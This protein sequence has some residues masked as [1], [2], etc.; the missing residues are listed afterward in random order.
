MRLIQNHN[1]YKIGLDEIYGLEQVMRHVLKPVLARLK[2]QIYWNDELDLEKLEYKSR[3]GFIAYSTNLGG[4]ELSTIIPKCEEYN[5][6]YI[7]FGECDDAE[8][9][10]DRECGC[11]SE[12]HLDA[13]L[14]VMLKV[15]SFDTKTGECEFY[16]YLGGGNGDAPYFRTKSEETYF[17]SEFKAKT[18][19]EFKTKAEKHIKKLLEK[20]S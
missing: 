13:K 9:D 8:C 5:F 4:L 11:E 7:N 20:M 6:Q 17:G 16:L 1:S 14:R 12:G 18:L 15:E 3:D 10:H 19:T 2:D